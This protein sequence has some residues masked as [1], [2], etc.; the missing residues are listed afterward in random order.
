MNKWIK[1]YLNRRD[2]SFNCGSTARP[3]WDALG[4]PLRRHGDP[5]EP[6]LHVMF[7]RIISST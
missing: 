7:L 5:T 6:Y 3:K 1:T 4:E 2:N